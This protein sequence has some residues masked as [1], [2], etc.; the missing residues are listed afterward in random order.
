MILNIFV[1]IRKYNDIE[2]FR[3]KCDCIKPTYQWTMYNVM[4][5]ANYFIGLALKHDRVLTHLKLQK[6]VYFAHGIYYATYDKPLINASIEAWQYGPVIPVLYR[7]LRH[8]GNNPIRESI[9]LE[10]TDFIMDGKIELDSKIRQ[11]LESIWD[12]M[13]NYSAT[14][15]STASHKEGSPWHEMVFKRNNGKILYSQDIDQELI[16]EYF[17]TIVLNKR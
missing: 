8:L 3:S 2:H 17:K 10:S 16:K 15:L 11:F 5:I 1:N 7:R 4:S 6:L 12:S 9:P 14:D 13:K